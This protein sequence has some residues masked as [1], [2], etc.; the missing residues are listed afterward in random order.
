M[1]T[2][3]R[4]GGLAAGAH[5]MLLAPRAA[6][7][8]L[9]RVCVMAGPRELLPSHAEQPRSHTAGGGQTLDRQGMYVCMHAGSLGDVITTTPARVRV[10]SAAAFSLLFFFPRRCCVD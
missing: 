5:V 8:F 1:P 4:R 10:R 9:P 7:V 3:R 6:L 2:V